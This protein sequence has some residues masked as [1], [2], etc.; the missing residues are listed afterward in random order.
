M[1]APHNSVGVPCHKNYYVHDKT[2]YNGPT[3]T[4][5]GAEQAKENRHTSKQRYAIVK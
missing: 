3:I 5:E 4:S 1:T 2:Q